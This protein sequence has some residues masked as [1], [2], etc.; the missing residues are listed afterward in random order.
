[1]SIGRKSFLSFLLA[2][3]T[4]VFGQN[5]GSDSPYGRY[6]YGNLSNTAIGAAE[7]MGGIGYGLRRSQQVN[8]TNPA[9]YSR[10]DTLT[11]IFDMGLSAQMARFND[12]ANVQNYKN[13]NLDYLAMQFPIIRNVGAS[14]GLLPLSKV[15]YNYG[16]NYFKEDIN[17]NETYRGT[18]GLNRIY[19]GIAYAPFQNFSVGV[20]V[21]YLFGDFS[22][23][24][25]L[26][27]VSI[28]GNSAYIS[29]RKDEYTV[30][31]LTHEWGL[32][33]SIPITRER[34]LTIGAVYTPKVSTKTTV[35]PF[36]AM[37]TRDPH[38]YPYPY[39]YPTYNPPVEIIPTDTLD[40]QTFQL[41]QSFGLGFTYAARKFLVG[42]DG[43]YQQWKNIEFP[44]SLDGMTIE[45][46]F[47]NV[48][49]VNA[50]V[51]YTIEPLSRNYLNRIRFRGGLSYA[52]SYANVMATDPST[53]NAAVSG[54]KEYGVNLGLGF[55]IRENL[56]GRVSMINIGFNYSLRQP[57][58]NF[59]IKEEMYKVF[60]N[61]NINEYWFFKRKFD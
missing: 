23:S 44:P 25:V 41:P 10:L 24:K 59:M 35:Y 52:N 30:N 48:S 42:I 49:R 6:G 60:V 4:T 31:T 15:G 16:K 18:G 3:G 13:G 14:L 28:T 61:V 45:N 40:A 7:S 9:S 33:Y 11:F 37:F 2:V 5:V 1:M 56:T 8:P 43:T 55:P 58:K 51:E 32:Q 46:R 19:G 53:G 26:T 21:S 57:D 27:P 17:Y 22:Y 34:T 50:G 54:Y 12:G 47:N 36:E 20:N 39:P 38:T 29:Q